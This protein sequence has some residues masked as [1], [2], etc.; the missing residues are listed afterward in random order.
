MKDSND[1]VRILS[2]FMS[3]SPLNKV[4]EL[5]NMIIF[6]EPLVGIIAADDILFQRLKETAAVG[7][8]HLTPVEWLPEA[9]TVISYFLPFSLTVRESNYCNDEHPSREWLYGRFEGEALNNA[10]KEHL[11]E[12]QKR[13]LP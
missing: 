4:E 10:M 2:K 7:E 11:S 3:N 1:I 9:K 12:A 13:A 6:D 8:H 5:N